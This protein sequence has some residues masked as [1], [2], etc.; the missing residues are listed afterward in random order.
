MRLG[1]EAHFESGHEGVCPYTVVAGRKI[2]GNAQL[3]K[4]GVVLQ[5]G[6]LLLDCDLKI[7]AKVLRLP[8]D[9][10]DAKVTTLKRELAK[11]Q[12][13]KTGLVRDIKSV[14]G[15]LREGFA[16]SL[17]IRL[18]DGSL[19]QFEID[20]AE[21]LKTKYASKEWTYLR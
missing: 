16:E 8:P 3:R 9:L 1:L 5:H 19:T 20:A 15:L 14:Q 18:M 13:G 2:S 17:D 4:A 10:V 6:T 7:M 12:T 11:K 21:K